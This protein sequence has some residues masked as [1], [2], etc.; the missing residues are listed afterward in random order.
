MKIDLITI[1]DKIR[2]NQIPATEL[3][4]I[5]S[6]AKQKDM[7]L[8]S[9]PLKDGTA[10]KILANDREIDCLIMRDGKVLTARGMIGTVEDI[11]DKINEIYK[12]ISK[13]NRAIKTVNTETESLD[14]IYK[15]FNKVDK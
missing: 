14:A 4:N 6:F 5:S 9:I 8:Q 10:A 12:H 2:T 1:A 13:R 7:M 11:A 15:Y 3:R